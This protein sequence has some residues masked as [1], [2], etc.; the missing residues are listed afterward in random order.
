MRK[1]HVEAYTDGA[2]LGNPGPGGWACILLYGDHRKELV[3]YEL[4]TTNQ[5]MELLAAV[6]ALE[7]LKRP[8]QVTL[9]SDSAY[10]INAFQLGWIDRWQRTGWQT[11][12]KNAVANQDLWERL[13]SLTDQHDVTWTKVKGHADNALNN[14]CDALARAAAKEAQAKVEAA[15]QG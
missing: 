11:K 6:K 10:L 8:C 2:C 13:V 7:A 1:A 9:Y 5:R 4:H 14:E 3:G 12:E 15:A